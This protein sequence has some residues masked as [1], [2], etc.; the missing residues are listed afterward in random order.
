MSK[1]FEY[2]LLHKFLPNLYSS[3]FQFGFKKGIGCSDAI[4][5]LNQT[6]DYFT[7][8]GSTVYMTARDAQKPFDR[9]NH[10]KLFNIL[11]NRNLPSQF[12]KTIVNWYMKIS[13]AFK[14][15]GALSNS[16]MVL[17]G[18]RQGGILSPLLFNMYADVLIAGLHRVA[19]RFI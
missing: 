5:V 7:S 8:R 3:E 17:S 4:F 6:V 19:V 14:W 18:I 11:M 1:V 9:V 12:I 2:C 13:S 15:N 16:V 10:V